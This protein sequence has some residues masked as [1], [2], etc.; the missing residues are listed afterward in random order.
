MTAGN[1]AGPTVLYV[2]YSIGFGGA[3]KSL[4]LTLRSLQSVKKIVAT[5]QGDDIVREW[6]PDMDV[7][8]FR[9]VINYRLRDLLS[10]RTRGTPLR[11]PLLKMYA[12]ADVMVLRRNVS[13]F[14]HLIR[15]NAVDLVHLNNGFTPHEAIFAAAGENV[16]FLVHLRDFH[17]DD[18]RLEHEAAR[19]VRKVIAVSNAVGASLAHTRIPRDDI[20]TVYDP[21]DWPLLQATAPARDRIRSE[22]SIPGN[23]VAVGIFG[24]VIPWK[25]QRE[26]VSAAFLAMAENPDIHA[27]IVGDQSD[28]DPSYFASIRRD[29]AASGLE[30]RFRLVGYRSNVEEFYAAMDIVVHASITP[31]PFG[32]VVPEAMAAGRAVIAARAGGPCEVVTDGVDGLLVEPGDVPALAWAIASLSGD[33]DRRHAMGAAGRAKAA[34]QFSIDASAAR[35]RDVYESILGASAMR[36]RDDRQ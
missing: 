25:G 33:R 2:D 9:R 7:R 31:E 19:R 18:V 10:A 27:I 3:V 26:F 30:S 24:R 4:S 15:H 6:F 11:W 20:V 29:I 12:G 23:A 32:M 14:R 21:V 5:S 36:A 1:R 8:P 35:V 13:F 16:P 34:A 22:C 28:G 17:R